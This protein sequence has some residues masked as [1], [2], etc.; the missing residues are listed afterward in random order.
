MNLFGP[1]IH[2]SGMGL[3]LL[4]RWKPPA[5]L[6]MDVDSAYI[7]EARQKSPETILV[8]RVYEDGANFLEWSP[9]AWVNRLLAKFPTYLPDYFVTINEPFGHDHWQLFEDFDAWQSQVIILLQA[10]GT[11]GLANCFGTGNFT[12]APDRIKISDAFPLTCAVANAMG[13]HDYSWPELQSGWSWHAGR[14]FQWYDDILAATGKEMKFLVGECGLTQCVI[15]DRPDHGWQSESPEDVTVESYLA[16]LYWYLEQVIT[17]DAN[18]GV[19]L[20]L[21][22]FNFYDQFHWS[23]EHVNRPEVLDAVIAM[24]IIVPEPPEPNGGES[25]DIKVFDKFG[26]ELL[27]VDAEDMI[28]LHGLSFETPPGLSAGDRYFKLIELREKPDASLITKVLDLYG[29]P[30]VNPDEW[31]D[32]SEAHR[33]LWWPN[34]NEGD[35][36]GHPIL[37]HFPTDYHEQADCGGLNAEGE[38]GSGM[39]TGAYHDPFTPGPHECWV[40]HPTIWSMLV[41]GQGMLGATDHLH[42]DMAFQETVYTNGEPPEP[43]EPPVDGDVTEALWAIKAELNEADNTLVEIRDV[44]TEIRDVLGYM[45]PEFP[46]TETFFGQYFD[47]I[48]L[49]DAPAF[50]REDAEINFF[51]VEDGPGGNVSPDQFSVLWTGSFTFEAGN[52]TFHALVDDGIRLWVDGGLT[53]DAWKDQSPTPYDATVWLA[54][55][56]HDVTVE[57]YENAGDATCK[58]WWEKS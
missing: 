45:P 53:I 44:L 2:K 22:L 12:A 54:A 10:A 41:K 55:G 7:Q 37:T 26:G 11:D 36:P 58:V 46:T 40:R 8:V 38:G 13:P 28:A 6:A 21:C 4:E 19:V 23:F 1:H 14:W 3:D 33:A 52:H 56:K 15:P 42:L 47:N 24:D 16:T 25:M 34:I 18:R 35:G 31:L 5:A 20:G 30:I 49:E 51:W 50:T 57:Y 39:G 48:F 9:E 17:W 43:P 29:N 32:R 27:G